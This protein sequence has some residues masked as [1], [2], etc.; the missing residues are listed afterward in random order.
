MCTL[1][2][3]LGYMNCTEIL[4]MGEGKDLQLADSSTATTT[5][6]WN[7]ILSFIDHSIQT[8]YV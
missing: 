3:L 4:L 1:R 8:T 2:Q 6:I 7:M 5:A